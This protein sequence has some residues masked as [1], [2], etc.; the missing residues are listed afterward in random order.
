VLERIGVHLRV[1]GGCRYETRMT[2]V[3]IWDRKKMEARTSSPRA[4]AT[5]VRPAQARPTKLFSL[6]SV[7]LRST[8]ALSVKMLCHEP[9][10]GLRP[11]AHFNRDEVFFVIEGTYQ[12]TADD[13]SWRTGPGTI[14]LIPRN[15]VHRLENVGISVARIL[16][17]SLC[18]QRLPFKTLSELPTAASLPTT[19]QPGDARKVG[20]VPCR[21]LSLK[22]TPEPLVHSEVGYEKP[23]VCESSGLLPRTPAEA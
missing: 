3:F 17:W 9:G 4:P 19:R 5:V 12:L 2:F 16:D 18:R 13:R 8:G 21:V 20:V 15:V 7:V 6:A 1:N 14:V 22:R 23:L 11:Q 10:E